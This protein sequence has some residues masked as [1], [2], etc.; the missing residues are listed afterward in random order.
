VEFDPQLNTLLL[1][2]D[3]WY[4]VGI[5]LVIIEVI[6]GLEFFVLAFGIGAILTG[7]TIDL[8]LLPSWL[9]YWERTFLVFSVLSLATLL[10]LKKLIPKGRAKKDISDY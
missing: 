6:I 3:F 9:V 1:E 5:G 8:S 10:V 2:A 4:L 7:A